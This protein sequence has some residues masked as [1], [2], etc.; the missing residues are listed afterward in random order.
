MEAKQVVT[1]TLVLA[2]VAGLIW[3]AV[4]KSGERN[5]TVVNNSQEAVADLQ[6]A[7]VQLGAPAPEAT[8]TTIGGEKMTLAQLKGE[9]VMFWYLATW[10]PSC[11]AGAQVLEDKNDQLGDLTIVALETFGNAGF[12]GPSMRDFALQNAPNMLTASNW[13]WGNASQEGTQ[14]YNPKNSPD[15]YYLIDEE[16][17]VRDID[18]APA[19]RINEIVTFANE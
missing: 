15:I 14:T 19:S 1:N 5:N 2:F 13:L 17:I 12:S 9:K 10:C 7:T 8:F 3:L 11:I 18:T 4:S 16:G 6:I